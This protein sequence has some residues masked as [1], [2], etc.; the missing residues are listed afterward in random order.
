MTPAD[1]AGFVVIGSAGLLIL[2]MAYS[3]IRS[4]YEKYVD[5]RAR[6]KKAKQKKDLKPQSP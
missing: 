3:A 4:Q 5:W 2:L 1:N 6:I